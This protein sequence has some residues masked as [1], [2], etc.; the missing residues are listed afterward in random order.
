M[1]TTSDTASRSDM[2]AAEQTVE[3]NSTTRPPVSG[4]RNAGEAG[5][6]VGVQDGDGVVESG[7]R[8]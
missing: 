1:T 4:C 7:V 6:R 8:V 3:R 5:V 2:D